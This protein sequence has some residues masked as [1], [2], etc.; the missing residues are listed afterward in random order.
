MKYLYAQKE[1]KLKQNN[2]MNHA[3]SFLLIIILR[4][5]MLLPVYFSFLLVLEQDL[6][7]D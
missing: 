7:N 1:T 5:V 6:E 4:S 2:G 3:Q